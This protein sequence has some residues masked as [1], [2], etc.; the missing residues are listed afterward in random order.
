MFWPEGVIVM[1]VPPTRTIS[2][3]SRLREE[4]PFPP[5]DGGHSKLEIHHPLAVIGFALTIRSDGP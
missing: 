2:P 1:P 5:P 3:V 4:T